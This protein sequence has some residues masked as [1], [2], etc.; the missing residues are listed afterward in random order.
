MLGDDLA[1]GLCVTAIA[2]E[3]LHEQR[4][5]SLVLH[6]EVKHHLV[7][8]WAMIAAVAPGNVNHLRVR[9]LSTVVAAIDM[10]T[11]AIEMGKHRGKPE[12]WRRRGRNKTVECR[13]AIVIEHI[14]GAAQRVLM[15]MLGRDPRGNEALRRFILK[16]P[17]DE[18]QLL[19]HKAQPIKDHRFDRVA[20]SNN[21][22]FW[23]VLHGPVQYVPNA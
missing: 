19:I 7:E 13:D 21:A 12:A 6:N 22:G 1:K 16:K 5:A 15:E 23:I 2:T 20:P 17:R 4:N 11:G 10:E 8:V 3:G 9:L 14:Q 18:V